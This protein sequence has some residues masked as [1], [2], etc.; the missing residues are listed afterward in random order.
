MLKR[1][2]KFIHEIGAFGLMGS[3]AACLILT[4]AAPT[5]SVEAYVVVRQNVAAI[6]NW[7]LMPSLVAVLLS[8]LLAIAAHS[9]YH[10]AA[11]AWTKALLGIAMFEG[12]FL[13]IGASTRRAAELSAAL[14]LGHTDAIRPDMIQGEWGTLW[15]LLV[16]SVVNIGLAV[17][18]PRFARSAPGWRNA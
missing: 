12:S 11:W 7:L 1:A 3:L 15:L 14:A 13:T 16:L 2:L 17:W 10:N 4:W 5:R 6:M 8:G 9:A 18:R